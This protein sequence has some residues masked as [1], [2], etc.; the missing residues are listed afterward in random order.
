MLRA[1]IGLGILMMLTGFGAAGWQYWQ[2]APQAAPAA[3]T[4]APVSSVAWLV[5]PSGGVVPRADAEAFLLQ[6]RFV[7]SR[8]LVLTRTAPLTDLLV[9]GESLPDAAYLQVMA[10]IRA[11]KLAEELCPVL[12][13]AGAEECA[14][15]SARVVAD[16]VD[17]LRGTARFRIELV[18]R[19]GVIIDVPDLTTHA[20]TVQTVALDPAV[21]PETGATVA[22]AVAALAAAAREACTDA[23]ACRTLRLQLDWTPDGPVSGTAEVGWLAPL[24]DGMFAAPPI[25]P[26]PPEG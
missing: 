17:L 10:D 5:S 12:M 8:S 19:D 15:Q 1:L 21:A 9:E 3:D 14:M 24:P 23:A 7:P 16:S 13:A 22:A 2:A 4:V 6:D 25:D 20:F 18:F 11:P 26:A